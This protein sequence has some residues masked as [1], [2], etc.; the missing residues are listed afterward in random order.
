MIPLERLD[1]IVG[2]MEEVIASLF[3]A[4]VVGGKVDV[5]GS[6]GGA[7]YCPVNSHVDSFS[8]FQGV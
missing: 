5:D 3:S 8:I 2:V 7:T 6:G 1:V 4:D